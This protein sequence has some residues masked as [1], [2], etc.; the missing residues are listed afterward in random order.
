[1]NSSTSRVLVVDDVQAN[2]DLTRAFIERAGYAV[3]TAGSGAEA[4]G[5]VSELSYDLVLM[6]IQMPGMDGLATTRAIRELEGEGRRVPV[7]ALTANV[8]PDQLESYAQAGIDG[9]LSKPFRRAQLL[10]LVDEKRKRPGE[11][12]EEAAPIATSTEAFAEA[13]Q[14]LG[15]ACMARA[16]ASFRDRLKELQ[17]LKA[18]PAELEH[19]GRRA[20][21]I[22][23]QAAMFGFA[24]FAEAL[25]DL[26]DCCKSGRDPSPT[27]LIARQ[28]AEE[29]RVL[30]QHHL[31]NVFF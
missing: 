19:L 5:R 12:V 7:I 18:N 22:I 25:A 29:A 30:V 11:A 14:L 4:L 1:M 28:Q 9:H 13:R 10:A 27:L 3:D 24:E 31:E 17:D 23:P 2:R 8:S 6:D 20:H 16:L 15:P 26:D 21:E